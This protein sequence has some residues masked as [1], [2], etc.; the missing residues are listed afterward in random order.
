MAP[1]KGG[2]VSVCTCCTCKCLYV[3]MRSLPAY[4]EDLRASLCARKWMEQP[5]ASQGCCLLLDE[6]LQLLQCLQQMLQL[7]I[8]LV[9][10]FL[11]LACGA[12]EA[13]L[14]DGTC[15]RI[16][17]TASLFEPT[18]HSTLLLQCHFTAA[19]TVLAQ[20]S[21]LCVCSSISRSKSGSDRKRLQAV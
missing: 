1:V 3:R 16:I 10:R 6:S 7:L 19:T 2:S 8:C 4:G 13:G 11:W 15:C 12:Q 5:S 18:L 14:L 9:N 17:I 20:T 21:A